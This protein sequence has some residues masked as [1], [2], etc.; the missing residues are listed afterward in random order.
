MQVQKLK[1]MTESLIQT[2][3]GPWKVAKCVSKIDGVLP[4]VV[5]A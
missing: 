1:L 5:I 2:A 4:A 3:D